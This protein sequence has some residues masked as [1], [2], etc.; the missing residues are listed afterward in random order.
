MQ[1]HGARRPRTPNQHR[2]ATSSPGYP[3]SLSRWAR[4]STQRTS[5]PHE[6][7]QV[8]GNAPGIQARV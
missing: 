2:K 8:E 5:G 4:P 6:G 3:T 1:S 7:M